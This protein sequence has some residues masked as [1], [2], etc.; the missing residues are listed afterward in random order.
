VFVLEEKGWSSWGRGEGRTEGS[1]GRKK[2]ARKSVSGER[3]PRSKE[4]NP[5]RLLD[6]WVG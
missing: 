2:E 5:E 6:F 3:G 1:L 4:M